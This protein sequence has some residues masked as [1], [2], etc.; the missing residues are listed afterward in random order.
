MIVMPISNIK[1]PCCRRYPSRPLSIDAII[2]RDGKLLLIK[3]KL[4][5]FKGYW[6]LPGGHVD[7]GETVEN[8]VTREVKEETN[9]TVTKMKLHGVYSN[10]KRHPN[11]SV[12][13]SYIT[14]T[15]G[16]TKAGD[17]ALEFK[18]VPL[19]EIP[20][21]LAFDHNRILDDYVKSVKS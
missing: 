11:Q 19:S 2:V 1:C 20:D 17:D 10:P 3:R 14:D 16:N 7:F 18:F 8:A 12:A 21:N 4:E 13:I 15:E 6:A 9:L 5:P